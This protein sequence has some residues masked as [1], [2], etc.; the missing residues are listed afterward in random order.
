MGPLYCIT[1]PVF[2]R[3]ETFVFSLLG[4]AIGVWGVTFKVVCICVVVLVV[5]GIVNEGVYRSKLGRG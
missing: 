5:T 2:S 3:F 4:M 1:R